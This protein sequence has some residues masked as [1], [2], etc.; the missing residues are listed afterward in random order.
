MSIPRFWVSEIADTKLLALDAQES[1]HALTSLRLKVGDEVILFDGRGQE[2]LA[3][4]S[5]VARRS[6][7]TELI[8]R[9]DSDRELRSPLHLFIA[10]PK[11]DRQRTLVE[12]LV[13]L[14]ATQLS[15]L[16]CHRG[17]AQPTGNAVNRLKKMVIEACKQSGRN[18]LMEVT[19]PIQLCELAKGAAG[20]S[21]VLTRSY[22]AH[23]YGAATPL[24][25]IV[26]NSA[27]TAVTQ[28][29][30]GPEGGFVDEE[31]ER[32]I[33]AGWQQVS[34]GKRIL[35]IEMAAMYCAAWHALHNEQVNDR[36]QHHA[37]SQQDDLGKPN[38]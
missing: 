16:C 29:A 7:T 2:V 18:Q 22:I 1:Q 21:S 13:Q 11:G 28:I 10:L 3:R 20:N 30:I 24:S 4:I 8:Q 17:V 27:A 25:E 34:L 26:R 37:L 19:E 6:V 14:G 12:G 15:P 36:L 31:V 33:R 32:F 5:D 23:P 38:S 35:R 9:L